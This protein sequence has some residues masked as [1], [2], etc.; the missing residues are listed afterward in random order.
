MGNFLW[1]TF[2]ISIEGY[3]LSCNNLFNYLYGIFIFLIP[4]ENHCSVVSSVNMGINAA[5]GLSGTPGDISTMLF[6]S[7][8]GGL[9]SKL[10]GGNFWEGA[11]IGLTVSGL[12][13]VAHRST[14]K[15][16]FEITEEIIEPTTGESEEGF[17]PPGKIRFEGLKDKHLKQFRVIP[18]SS[19]ELI[20]PNNDITYQTDGF[21]HQNTTEDKYWYK[22]GGGRMVRVT[23][24]GKSFDLSRSIFNPLGLGSYIGWKPKSEP[25]W[26]TNPFYKQ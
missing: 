15:D 12:N 9:S 11:A 7:A 2:F 19:S 10:A 21:Y 22:I 5:A 1:E 17:L 26:T 24:N 20:L 6:G 16:S 8:S 4:I 23:Y 14:A 25:H 3:Y 13:H 18:E